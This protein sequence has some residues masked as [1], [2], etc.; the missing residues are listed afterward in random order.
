MKHSYILLLC[1]TGLSIIQCSQSNTDQNFNPQVAMV[2]NNIDNLIVQAN[3]DPLVEQ[4]LI[5]EIA[6][7]SQQAN[8]NIQQDMEEIKVAA[9]LTTIL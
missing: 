7:L 6:N 2:Q 5:A 3:L 8:A 1:I 9:A 4:A